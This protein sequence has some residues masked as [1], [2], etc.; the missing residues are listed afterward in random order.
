M[1][2]S[3]KLGTDNKGQKPGVHEDQEE[4]QTEVLVINHNNRLTDS[5]A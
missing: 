5:L 3:L 4:R 2:F 1:E